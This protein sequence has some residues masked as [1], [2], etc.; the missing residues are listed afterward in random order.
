MWG[1]HGG[2]GF[3][4]VCMCVRDKV[5]CCGWRACLRAD[6]SRDMHNSSHKEDC[7]PVTAHVR[8]TA[9]SG[10]ACGYVGSV[11]VVTKEVPHVSGP[12]GGRG[13]ERRRRKAACA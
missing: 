10:E 1:E 7:F 5:C 9:A 11:C 6:P 4:R 8:K 12:S 13:H 2:S 3:S